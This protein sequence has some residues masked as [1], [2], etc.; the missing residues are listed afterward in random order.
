[1]INSIK[2]ISGILDLGNYRDAFRAVYAQYFNGNATTATTSNNIAGLTTGSSVTLNI[3][4]GNSSE[5]TQSI[6]ETITST[7][8]KAKS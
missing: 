3:Q 7:V 1:M 4:T 8:A 6:D 2:P 5:I